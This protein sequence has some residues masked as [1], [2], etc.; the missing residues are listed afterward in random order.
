MSP[1]P[2]QW[3][4]M[5]GGTGTKPTMTMARR[6]LSSNWNA[7]SPFGAARLLLPLVALCFAL[8]PTSSTLHAAPPTIRN[9]D[10]PYDPDWPDVHLIVMNKCSGC[11]RPGTDLADYT[12]Y[13]KLIA[14][15]TPD[16]DRIILPGRPDVSPLWK[17]V[18]WNATGDV[19][20]SHPNKPEMPQDP[21][22]WLAAGQLE[23]VRRWIENGALEYTLP[24][25]CSTRPLLE[26]DFPSSRQCRSCHPKQY[27]EWS[28]SMHH[29]AQQSPV[30]EAFNLTMQER[31]SG[32][33][34]TFCSRCHTPIGTEL[35]EN[36]SIRNVNRSQLSREGVSCVSC[37]RIQGKHYKSN[38]RF[39]MKP[40]GLLDTCMYGP[41]D[42]SAPDDLETHPSASKPYIKTSAFC[43]SCHDVTSPS[44]VRLEEAFSEWQNS[45]AAKQG[46]TCQTCHMGPVQGKPVPEDHRP[47]G[48][49]ATV[50]GVDPA[51]IPLRRLSDHTFAGPDYSMLPDTEFPHK[52]DWMYE[53]DYRDTKSL[54]PYQRRT[55]DQLRRSN[56]RHL[57]LARE[58]RYELLSNTARLDVKVPDH[59]RPGQRVKA[60]VDVKSL[61][62]G[63]SFPTG[64]TAERQLWVQITVYDPLG[65]TIF[66]SGTL[67]DNGDL[68]DSHSHAV[69]LGHARHDRF[70]LNFQNKFVATS[71]VGTDRTVVLTVNRHL[72]PLSLMRPATSVAASFGRPPTFR[73]AKG[74]LAPLAV[75]GQ[76]YP[77]QLASL[78]GDYLVHVRLN[79]RNLPPVLLDNIGT[80]HLKHLLEIVT[81]DEAKCV[82]HVRHR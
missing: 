54:T 18:A 77:F 5:A 58:K 44:G 7:T 47:L 32:T 61:V 17:Y 29:Y 26:I 14:A 22:E 31:T 74:S 8:L 33:M 6:M 37:H 80:P 13:E 50:P 3:S 40:G 49:A 51:R 30:F 48:R 59:A 81:V 34:G 24:D 71:A 38:A 2:T 63:H 1:S 28:R 73:I 35:G 82:I 19:N 53:T 75:V 60:C 9:T 57:E 10:H 20:S 79:F 69:E 46:H 21:L 4:A 45:P 52:L 23:I 55:L 67:D 76:T 16:G 12:S 62:A 39:A 41:F 72:A 15:V 65:Q 66:C 11:H 27:N 56:R 70:L 25:T 36:G 43:G 42:D 68:R 78:E 64:F